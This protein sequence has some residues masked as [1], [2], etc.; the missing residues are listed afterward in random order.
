MH[1]IFEVFV[2]HGELKR[3]VGM[4]LVVLAVSIVVSSSASAQETDDEQP[5]FAESTEQVQ[6]L[7]DQAVSAIITGNYPRAIALLEESRQIAESNIVYLNLG[8]AYQKIGNCKKAREALEK[9]S[10]APIVKDPSPQFVQEKA[11]QYLAEVEEECAE[12]EAAEEPESSS[13]QTD[14]STAEPDGKESSAE[15]SSDEPSDGGEPDE[16]DEPPPA[17]SSGGWKSGVGWAGV[18]TGVALIG[19]GVALHFVAESRRNS[20]GGDDGELASVTY[21]EAQNIER[22]A[23]NLDTIGLGMGIGGAVLAGVGAYF[24]ATSGSSEADRSQ[25]SL[26][27]GPHRASVVWGLRW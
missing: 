15:I 25:V 11:D 13:E 7:N 26:R 14:E 10:T 19:G 18:G 22:D 16:L 5:E 3:R 27:V 9:V 24:L 21:A 20:I 17:D 1:A 8:R 2:R 12:E 4:I 6:K 23:N